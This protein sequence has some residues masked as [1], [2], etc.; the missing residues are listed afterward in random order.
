MTRLALI[1]LIVA[2][3]Q[4]RDV[5]KPAATGAAVIGGVV[6]ADDSGRPVRRAV[7]R[8][9]NAETRQSASVVTDDQGRFVIGELP[10]GRYALTAS[11]AGWLSTY[12]GAK[13]SWRPPGTSIALADR[14]Q[15]L[16][17]TVKLVRSAVFT[18][19]VLDADGRPAA[20]LRPVVLEQQTVNGIRR[21]SE[22][23]GSV[24]VLTNTDDRGEFRLFGFAPGT[25]LVGVSAPLGPAATFRRTT[26]AELQWAK[27]QA[28]PGAAS[29]PAPR[30]G[31]A[32][33]FAP[34]YY[35]GVTDA[36]SA[37]FITVT[38]GE[39][40]TGLDFVANT[41]PMARLSGVVTKPDGSP[42]AGA[43]VILAPDNDTAVLTVFGLTT[44][45]GTSDATG[46][47]TIS[48]VRPGRYQASVRAPSQPRPADQRV[49]ATGTPGAPVGGVLDLWANVTLDVT[50]DP[51]ENIALALQPGVDVSGRIAIDGVPPVPPDLTRLRI[52]LLPANYNSGAITSNNAYIATANADGTFKLP[53]VA[54]D[55]YILTA[56]G[57]TSTA[58]PLM[59]KS[60]NIGGRDVIDSGFEVQGQS[61]GDVVMTYTTKVGEIAGTLFDA[62]GAAAPQYYVFVFPADRASWTQQSRR[63]RPPTRPGTD[64]KFRVTNLPP[65]DYLV[66][67]LTD[68]EENAFLDASFIDTLVPAAIKITLAEGE[69]K[70]QDIKISGG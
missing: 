27:Q 50:G 35:P 61:I 58:S 2:S 6:L 30:L 37:T 8:V 38:A 32:L 59:L 13:R 22:V 39:E 9:D 42:A 20:N 26:A 43:S 33:G 70:V 1:L 57:M 28:T 52:Q 25:Y 7:I 46:K 48:P 47:F 40:R 69:K 5:V 18:G 44:P 41:V 55:R 14:Q 60:V 12:Y 56:T 10:A 15:V 23:I 66:V 29:T 31:N 53:G 65:G 34:V 16:T 51:I 45:R 62:A 17:L 68:F 67:A 54:P 21:F 3:V 49:V 19:R 36:T 64:G 63:F 24:G 11:K 4:G